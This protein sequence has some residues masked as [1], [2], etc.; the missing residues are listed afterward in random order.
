V[1]TE[2]TYRSHAHV[3]LEN[4]PEPYPFNGRR[5]DPG[6]EVVSFYADQTPT[7]DMTADVAREYKIPVFKT[8]DAVLP[9]GEHGRYPRNEA[10]ALPFTRRPVG[11][12]L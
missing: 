7:G 8:I 2:F 9:I 11:A 6:V 4:F 12:I 3:I 10:P 5:A 1:F